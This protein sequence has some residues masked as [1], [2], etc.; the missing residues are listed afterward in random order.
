MTHTSCIVYD[1]YFVTSSELGTG[2]S[3]VS[4]R[5]LRL[6]FFVTTC[7]PDR[8]TDDPIRPPFVTL[9]RDPSAC[10]YRGRTLLKGQS[11]PYSLRELVGV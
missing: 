7:L 3:N 2:P 11:I 4:R 10:L 6:F 1:S 8:A 5:P 9:L